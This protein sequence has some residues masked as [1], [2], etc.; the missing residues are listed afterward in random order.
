MNA[1]S[2]VVRLGV[3][4]GKNTFHLVGV[5]AAGQLALK[6]K[7][8]R[9]NLLAFLA[10]LEPCLIGLEACGGAHHWARE[11]AKLGH[12]VRLMNPKFVKA[13]VQGNKND[14]NDAAAICEA[15]GRPGM[16]FVAVKTVEQQEMQVLH[17]LRSGAVKARTALA[18]Q[19][20]GVLGEF[21]LVVGQGLGRLRRALPEILEDAD[22]GLSP[23]LRGWLAE[24]SRQLRQWDEQVEAYD[25]E[26]ERLYRADE[27][28]RRLG[29]V[30]GIGPV[31][32]TALV[33]QLADGR[34][35]QHGRQFSASLG[36]VPRQHTT[37]G[38]PRLL[39]ISKRG[40]RYLRTQLIH[41][42]R[43]VVSRI[44]GKT[45]ALSRWLQRLVATRGKNKAAVA[46]ANKNA[47][48]AWALLVH[49]TSYRPT[50]G[51]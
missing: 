38:E 15:V 32:A 1:S 44:E 10:Q 48:I 45:D 47:R 12:E 24:L 41:G 20:R 51:V 30:P 19:I 39:G 28:C 40:D 21:G 22:N 13:Y 3:D 9:R 33:G 46:L 14:Y 50:A 2:K 5:D 17:R 25:E 31:V 26:V 4:L 16:R 27:A 49:G 6:K 8:T 29:Q 11:M 36:L 23:R 18:N 42:A 34:G 43:A 37:G 7:R 35:F